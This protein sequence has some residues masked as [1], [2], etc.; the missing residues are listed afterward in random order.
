MA[1]IIVLIQLVVSAIALSGCA[2]LAPIEVEEAFSFRTIDLNVPAD[3]IL[4][5]DLGGRSLNAPVVYP[6]S[7]ERTSFAE[8][9][10]AK[11][12]MI[13][14]IEGAR[15]SGGHLARWVFHELPARPMFSITI[16]ASGLPARVLSETIGSAIT[17]LPDDA[18]VQLRVEGDLLPGAESVLRAA[19]LRGL[20]PPTMT[21]DLRFRR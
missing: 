16:D 4:T 7:I 19:H 2:S 8:R 11:G 20:H 3:R 18:V 9:D 14:E 15:V 21:V 13:L 12:F 10:E 6:G 5:H 1:R 17:A